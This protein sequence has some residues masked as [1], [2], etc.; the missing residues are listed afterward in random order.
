MTTLGNSN[1]CGATQNN[2]Q[3]Q[4]E[5]L[6]SR[7]ESNKATRRRVNCT[8]VLGILVAFWSREVIEDTKQIAIRIGCGELVK[9]PG[10]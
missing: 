3:K 10:L 5:S 6:F 8:R 2:F 1:A 4:L 9:T 7:M